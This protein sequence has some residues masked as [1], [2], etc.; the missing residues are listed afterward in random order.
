MEAERRD[1]ERDQITRWLAQ[2]TGA[3]FATT[4]RAWAQLCERMEAETRR[5]KLPEG[6]DPFVYFRTVEVLV[7]MLR[8]LS[9]EP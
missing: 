8:E 3:S 2:R 4:R 7:S 1:W 5:R 9:E 6:V